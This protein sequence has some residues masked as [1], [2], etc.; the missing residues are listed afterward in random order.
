MR[1]S[2]RAA[3]LFGV[4]VKVHA[5][6]GLVLV[7]GAVQW[8]TGR[9]AAGALF[10][11]ALMLALF[12][13][14]VLHELGHSLVAR[15]F[16]VP[17][18]EIVL[19]PIGGVALMGPMP[20]S[21]LRELAI[22]VAGPLVNVL[23]AGL[24]APATGV[25]AALLGLDAQGLVRGAGAPSVPTFLLWLLGANVSLAVFNMV[26]AFP[27]DGGRILRALLALCL[28]HERATKVAAV[29]GQLIA[30]AL[31][32]FGL[33][34]GAPTLLL[35]ALFIFLGATGEGRRARLAPL[36][37][38]LSAR[39]ACN[40]RALRLAPQDTVERAADYVLAAHQPDF[41]VVEEDRLLGVVTR[42]DLVDALARGGGGAAVAGIMRSDAPRAK[43]GATLAEVQD[44]LYAAGARVAAVFDGERFLGLL[45]LEDIARALML[46]PWPERPG[47]G[48]APR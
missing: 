45:S 39:E 21:P 18:R 20:R 2:V 4:D 1:W 44:A 16:G 9:G 26:P 47:A 15:A 17:T 28:D 41:A 43:A 33:V 22:A 27:L 24:L 42:D 29:V 12:V 6:F 38:R 3:R 31:G 46:A 35:V 8:G 48:A 37:A 23:L 36:L 10:G 25:T 40:A 34:F 19:L 5:T 32:F 13:C 11:A 7:L 30:A 14:V